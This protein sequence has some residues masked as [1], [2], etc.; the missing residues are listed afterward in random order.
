[1]GVGTQFEGFL[2][3]TII[4]GLL[5]ILLFAIESWCS[6]TDKLK[7]KFPKHPRRV[8]RFVKNTIYVISFGL[9]LLITI[10]WIWHLQ[11]IVSSC[12]DTTPEWVLWILEQYGKGK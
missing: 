9:T 10:L 11:S 1:M 8:R 12:G 2:F 3:S 5:I 6:I 4:Y 7:I